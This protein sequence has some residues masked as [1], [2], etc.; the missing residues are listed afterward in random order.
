LN[1]GKATSLVFLRSRVSAD[2]EPSSI[3][4]VLYTIGNDETFVGYN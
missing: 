2:I 1:K 4:L 3:D